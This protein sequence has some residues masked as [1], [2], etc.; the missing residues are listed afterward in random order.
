MRVLSRYVASA[1]DAGP[2]A[3][4][5]VER[6][7]KDEY[8]AKIYTYRM[9]S[10]NNT[11]FEKIK[12]V[13]FGVSHCSKKDIT[14]IQ[15]PF[16]NLK[17]LYKNNK[18]IFVIIH[19]IGYFR[20]MDKKLLEKEIAI[21]NMCQGVIVHNKSMQQFL[22]DHGLAIPTVI[23]EFFDYLCDN[24]EVVSKMQKSVEIIY[25]GNWSKSK[26]EFLYQL[27]ERKMK[28]NINVYGPNTDNDKLINEK[29]SFKGSFKPDE[30]IYNINGN[31]GLVWSGKL[32]ESD[33][34]VGD[35]FYNLYNTPHKLS[36]FLAA[37]IPVIVWEKSAIADVVK[38][39]NIGYTISNIYDIN[40]IDFSNYDEVA[41][42]VAKLGKK[43]RNGYFT[44]RAISKALKIID[45]K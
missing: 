38:K 29:I 33:A 16:L 4:V 30:L 5:D 39:Y 45:K 32:D 23:L 6:I 3:K 42:N 15:F 31:V 28:F 17:W 41:K 40:N 9:K 12:K 18:K 34:N 26:A 37:N 19:D 27:E 10:Q 25:P 1:N 7:L 43:I 44:K 21:L 24:N 8:N 36:C 13:L 35:K 2:K 22:I 11:C 14:L 20:T